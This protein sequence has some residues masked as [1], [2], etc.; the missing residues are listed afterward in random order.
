MDKS[1]ITF[2]GLFLVL[3]LCLASCSGNSKGNTS[4]EV[5]NEIPSMTNSELVEHLRKE[6]QNING[7]CP[8]EYENG[9]IMEGVTYE[10]GVW[11]YNYL[12][13]GETFYIEDNDLNS[14][15]AIKA[16]FRGKPLEQK[17]IRALVQSNAKMVYH[18]H[19]QGG[20]TLDITLT[21]PELEDILE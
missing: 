11:Q 9:V 5:S 13:Q 6:A 21:T 17:F 18:Y 7:M 14:K 4:Q 10:S 3:T 8:M 16:S 19:T 15:E 1:E 2:A 12:V 20:K